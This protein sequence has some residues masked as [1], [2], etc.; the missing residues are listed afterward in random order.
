MSQEL[1]FSFEVE[2]EKEEDLGFNKEEAEEVSA[3]L[4]GIKDIDNVELMEVGEVWTL[5]AETGLDTGIGVDSSSIKTSIK[6]SEIEIKELA[7]ILESVLNVIYQRREDIVY[8]GSIDIRKKYP[9]NK[10]E[11]FDNLTNEFA[12]IKDFS[13][14][15]FDYEFD[16]KPLKGTISDLSDEEDL[17][18][19]SILGSLTIAHPDKDMPGKEI[20]ENTVGIT[21]DLIQAKN[22]LLEGLEDEMNDNS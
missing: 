19:V 17:V 14:I 9:V 15:G 5:F 22:E 3:K 2:S 16:N 13:L 21:E 1:S 4:K 20:E 11:L 7:E 12:G 10:E 8:K 6:S 18:L